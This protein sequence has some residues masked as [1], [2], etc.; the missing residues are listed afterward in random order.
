MGLISW[1]WPAYW[2]AC[3]FLLIGW[4]VATAAAADTIQLLSIVRLIVCLAWYCTKPFIHTISFHLYNNL[5][6]KTLFWSPLDKLRTREVGNLAQVSRVSDR[7]GIQA[8]KAWF[9]SPLFPVLPRD[10]MRSW[11]LSPVSVYSSLLLCEITTNCSSPYLVP[12]RMSWPEDSSMAV[13][14]PQSDSSKAD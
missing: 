3:S 10:L 1:V 5:V 2:S 13:S 8:L 14:C 11:F 12:A 7:A 4:V 9:L 6:L